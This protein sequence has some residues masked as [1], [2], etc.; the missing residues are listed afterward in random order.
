MPQS[1]SILYA[2]LVAR[3]AASLMPQRMAHSML[4]PRGGTLSPTPSRG[5]AVLLEPLLTLAQ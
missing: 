5:E 1:I 3:P 4:T 2:T